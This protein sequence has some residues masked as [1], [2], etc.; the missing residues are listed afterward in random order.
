MR[1]QFLLI[2]AVVAGATIFAI[3]GTLS[4]TRTQNYSPES[5][6]PYQIDSVRDEAQRVDMTDAGD[7]RRFRRAVGR[8]GYS[9]SVDFWASQECFNVS[10]RSGTRSATLDCVG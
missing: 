1:G 10:L 8:L 5:R 3:A 9:S 7:R 2:S 6:L 4:D